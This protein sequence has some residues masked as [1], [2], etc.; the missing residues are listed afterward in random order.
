MLAYDLIRPA[1]TAAPIRRWI[2]MLHG[3]GDSKQGWKPVAEHLALP[4]TGWIFAQAPDA[5]GPG[6]SWFDL[7][8]PDPF[9]D[10]R[11]VH[12]SRDLV[13]ELLDHLERQH[14]IPCEQL[15]L[16][17]FS[18]GCLMAMEVGLTHDRRFAGLVGISG[19]IA[20]L[21]SYPG[22]FGAAADQQHILLT[23][24]SADPVIPLSVTQ[25]QAKRLQSLGLDVEWHEFNKAHHLDE[26]DEI[27]LLRSF[28]SSCVSR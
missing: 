20:N 9:P 17:G 10:L 12:R 19:W 25:P 16:M 2:L 15:V 7:R 1:N 27:P 6:W 18:Q 28:L 22:A 3:L 5:Y 13:R 24:G 14:G 4:A 11:G 23:H 26:D 21:A 8:L